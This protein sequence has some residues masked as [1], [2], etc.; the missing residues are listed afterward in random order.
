MRPVFDAIAIS[1]WP[2][3]QFQAFGAL[4]GR[5]LVSHGRPNWFRVKRTAG[6]RFA[7]KL[8][9]C[10]FVFAVVCFAG[11]PAA[12]VAEA[13]EASIVISIFP[14]SFPCFVK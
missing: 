9:R 5:Q 7:G 6:H 8:P 13:G 12:V 1:R 11:P 3:H 10:H 4:M 2:P 14:V